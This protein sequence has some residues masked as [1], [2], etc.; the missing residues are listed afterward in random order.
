MEKKGLKRRVILF[1][2]SFQ[3]IAEM[4]GSLKASLRNTGNQSKHHGM[5]EGVADKAVIEFGKGGAYAV[6]VLEGD[7]VHSPTLQSR[8]PIGLVL[9][10]DN[11]Y[12]SFLFPFK[13]WPHLLGHLRFQAL[14]AG[15]VP[16][17]Q[18]FKSKG[19][20]ECS[21]AFIIRCRLSFVIYIS[22]TVEECCG[23]HLQ[24][25]TSFSAGRSLTRN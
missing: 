19:A 1:A 7:C 18:S 10:T 14:R 13:C 17:S 23:I 24:C 21:V 3:H 16:Y 11:L 12:H 20:S 25:A 9:A 6:N 15:D 8:N 5:G 4:E 22:N 2:V